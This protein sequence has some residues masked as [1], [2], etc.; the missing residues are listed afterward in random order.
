MDALRPPSGNRTEVARMRIHPKLQRRGFG[1]SIMK[2]LESKTA[3][4]G[5]T[6]L[7]L[8]TTAQHVPTQKLYIKTCY[9]KVG[10]YLRARFEIIQYEKSLPAV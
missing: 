4:L 9:V 7:H 6:G 2:H 8:E 1:E 3:E 5:H 10:R